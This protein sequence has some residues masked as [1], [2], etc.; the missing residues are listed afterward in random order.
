MEKDDSLN[1]SISDEA[2]HRTAPATPGLLISFK[3]YLITQLL[4]NSAKKY[5]KVIT[6]LKKKGG[7][8]RKKK[9]ILKV[10]G[11]VV[12]ALEMCLFWPDLNGN[13]FIAESHLLVINTLAKRPVH[14]FRLL[15]R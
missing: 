9:Y 5:P 1:Q 13:C 14:E 4:K 10:T 7:G 12:R 6:V 11:H 8:S 2:V 15:P 3:T